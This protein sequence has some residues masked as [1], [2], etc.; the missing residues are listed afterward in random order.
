MT[1]AEVER[2]LQA[3]SARIRAAGADLA[4]SQPVD[5][6]GL[7]GEA[8]ALCRALAALSGPE[9]RGFAPE[10]ARLIGALDRLAAA[11]KDR[12]AG[13]APAAADAMRVARAYGGPRG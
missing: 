8:E 6:A 3:A 2:R 7:E 12:K 1:A 9:A 10:V 13:P 5:L 11:L 4:R